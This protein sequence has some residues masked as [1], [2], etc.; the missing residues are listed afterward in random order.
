MPPTQMGSIGKK[1]E[2]LNSKH[3]KHKVSIEYISNCIIVMVWYYTFY[4]LV[5][6]LPQENQ[7]D[8]P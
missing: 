2:F 5:L 7:M 3:K 4:L 8:V 6:S 1:L